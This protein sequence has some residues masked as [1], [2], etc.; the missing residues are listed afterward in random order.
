MSKSF[1]DLAPKF[2][3]YYWLIGLIVGLISTF[4]FYIKIYGLSGLPAELMNPLILLFAFNLFL[5][6]FVITKCR[7]I[8]LNQN[9]G[10]LFISRGIG[11]EIMITKTNLLIKKVI[12]SVGLYKVLSDV[13]KFYIFSTERRIEEYLRTNR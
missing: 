6:V 3:F 8:I 4:F 7:Y 12:P 11:R 1:S 2:D 9:N 10:N 5:F 13:D